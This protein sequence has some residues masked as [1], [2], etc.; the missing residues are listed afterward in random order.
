MVSRQLSARHWS[1]TKL[2]SY[3][4]PAR[5]VEGSSWN[6]L[7]LLVSSTRLLPAAI[8]IQF[9]PD[10]MSASAF[11]DL[12]LVWSKHQAGQYHIKVQPTTQKAAETPATMSTDGI[13]G[14]LHAGFSRHNIEERLRFHLSSL[15]LWLSF[16]A[17]ISCDH[18]LQL[19]VIGKG[20]SDKV[21]VLLL[22]V[23][24]HQL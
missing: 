19:C 3:I 16:H 20:T 12:S 15:F 1:A 10:L 14:H 8:L 18:V 5:V 21:D 4:P 11:R 7:W 23:P 6:H 2:Q 22:F 13:L 9:Q 17:I 24:G